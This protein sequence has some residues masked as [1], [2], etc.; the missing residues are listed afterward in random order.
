M[1]ALA[2][3]QSIVFLILTV[4]AFAVELVAFVDS[5]RYR[6]EVYRAA[7]KKSKTFWTVL[8]GISAAV[9]F[10]AMPP[11]SLMPIFISLLGFVAA[12]VYFTD[13]RKGLRS[14]DPRYRGR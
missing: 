10:L 9:G 4:A 1:S 3:A 5:L 7:D 12:A 14:V 8:L 6:D 11:L 2:S 13:V